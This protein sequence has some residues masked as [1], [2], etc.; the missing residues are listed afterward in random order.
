MIFLYDFYSTIVTLT[1]N[2]YILK[3]VIPLADDRFNSSFYTRYR[4]KRN[5]DYRYFHSLIFK[6]DELVVFIFQRKWQYVPL[7]S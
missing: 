5:R 6:Q 3:I 4:V 7:N 2:Y 1:I